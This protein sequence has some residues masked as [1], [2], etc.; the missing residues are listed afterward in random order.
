MRIATAVAVTLLALAI[1]AGA[2]AAACPRTTLGDVENEVMC[3]VCGTPLGL[4]TEAPQAN[5]EREFIRRQVAACKS[6]DEVKAAL[7]AEFGDEVLALPDDEGFGLA[8]YLV[9]GLAL[10]IGAGAIGVA[11]VRWR[12]RRPP[13]SNA[14]GSGVAGDSRASEDG[15]RLD[16]D[17]ERYDL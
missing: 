3:P 12:R 9:P 2:L 16:S 13:G 6:K 14:G 5:R 7:A 10:V 4:A 1:P 15:K 17:L 11:A 8:A